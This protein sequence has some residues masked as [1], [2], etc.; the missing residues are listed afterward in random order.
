M[1][2]PLPTLPLP[3]QAWHRD[4]ASPI[5]RVS[6]WC[7]KRHFSFKVAAAPLPLGSSTTAR[8]P[9]STTSGGSTGLRVA[10]RTQEVR[11]RSIRGCGAT[12]SACREASKLESQLESQLQ[13]PRSQMPA[14]PRASLPSY[15]PCQAERLGVAPAEAAQL[16]LHCRRL[17]DTARLLHLQRHGVFKGGSVLLVPQSCSCRRATPDADAT[18]SGLSCSTHPGA[19]PPPPGVRSE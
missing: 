11:L 4:A 7:V 16:G 10:P 19:A 9:G 17:I 6:G 8:Q 15:R 1:A 3:T 5:T 14:E 12:A 13:S 2:L 18:A